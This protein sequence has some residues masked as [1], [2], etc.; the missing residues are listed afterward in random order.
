[1]KRCSILLE[2]LNANLN[3]NDKPIKTTTI[4]K[5]KNRIEKEQKQKR[6]QNNWKL[7]VLL[8]D[9]KMVQPERRLWSFLK[10][11]LKLPHDPAKPLLGNSNKLKEGFQRDLCIPMIIAAPFTT[12]KRQ[13]Q[14]KCP[15]EQT[16]KMWY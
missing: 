4:E 15:N 1:M 8:A 3:H 7:Y 10:K 6:M 9:C 5:E 13:K 12:A 14:L 16:E 2:K 11:I